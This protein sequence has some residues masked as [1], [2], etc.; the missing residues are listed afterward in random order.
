MKINIKNIPDEGLNLECNINLKELDL[1]HE[2]L[3]SLNEVKVGLHLQKETDTVFFVYGKMLTDWNLICS[4][5]LKIFS[6][7]INIEFKREYKLGE[8][9]IKADDEFKD[10]VVNTVFFTGEEIDITD[11]IRQDLLLAIPL[12][13]LCKDECRGIC[14][15][16][17]QD[18][19]FYKCNCVQEKFDSRWEALTSIKKRLKSK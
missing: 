13:T 6:Q 14:S 2:Q 16:C 5:C 11:D 17:G 15:Q 3:D 10:E 12:K 18:L 8:P 1:K 7:K 4:R 19:N 9:E